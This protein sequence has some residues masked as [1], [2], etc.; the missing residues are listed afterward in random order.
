ME[1]G[2]GTARE[3]QCTFPTAECRL[4]N[5]DFRKRLSHLQPRRHIQRITVTTSVFIR[6]RPRFS[7]LEKFA[8]PQMDA[9]KKN[10]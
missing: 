3:T 5:F 6:V 10:G 2:Q 7:H 4:T 8:E 9:D 1:Q